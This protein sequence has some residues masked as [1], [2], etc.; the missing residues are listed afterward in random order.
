MVSV[1]GFDSSDVLAAIEKVNPFANSTGVQATQSTLTKVVGGAL[2]S[3]WIKGLLNAGTKLWN[4]MYSEYYSNAVSL[5]PNP[6][7]TEESLSQKYTYANVIWNNWASVVQN[8][9][10]YDQ[11]TAKEK[12][13]FRNTFTARYKIPASFVALA[14]ASMQELRNAGQVPDSVWNPKQAATSEAIATQQA[15]AQGGISG[16][17]ANAISKAKTIASDIEGAGSTGLKV[18]SFLFKYR[19]P[20]VLA[21][22]GVAGYIWLKPYASALGKGLKRFRR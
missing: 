19:K 9:G 21:G 6:G 12:V 14:A 22:V 10:V 7:E 18:G 2:P 8:H 13:R 1:V 15:I 11:D 20:L 16:L 17:A 5:E 3:A 4:K